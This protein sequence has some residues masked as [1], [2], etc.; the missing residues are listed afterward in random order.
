MPYVTQA[1]ENNFDHEGVQQLCERIA[2]L[3]KEQDPALVA[4]ACLRYAFAIF[5][6]GGVTYEQSM[7]VVES[8][9]EKFLK[10]AN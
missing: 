10:R 1:N 2:E 5:S 8:L 3:S 7:E 9:G 4:H 6:L